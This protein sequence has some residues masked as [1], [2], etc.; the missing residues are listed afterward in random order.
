MNELFKRIIVKALIIRKQA[1]EDVDAVIATY[2]NLT[3]AE[4]VEIMK[5]VNAQ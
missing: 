3:E 2:T 1:G 5:E 4:K